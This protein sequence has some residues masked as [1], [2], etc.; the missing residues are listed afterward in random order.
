M[1]QGG[2]HPSLHIQ[3][4]NFDLTQHFKEGRGCRTEGTFRHPEDFEVNKGLAKLGRHSRYGGGGM[5][6]AAARVRGST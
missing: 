4:K 6:A 5:A 1:I 2:A 3:Y